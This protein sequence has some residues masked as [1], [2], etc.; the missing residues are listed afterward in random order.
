MK[1]LVIVA[2]LA[3]AAGGCTY[4]TVGGV[5][6]FCMQWVNTSPRAV[7]FTAV[8]GLGS[9]L[10]TQTMMVPALGGAFASDKLHLRGGQPVTFSAPSF[11]SVTFRPSGGSKVLIVEA[12]TVGA[13]LDHYED[14][15]TCP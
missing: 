1:R 7:Q 3:F 6:D 15:G 8:D 11:Q 5:A 2:S 9:T 10:S 12:H 4:P 14:N 13:L